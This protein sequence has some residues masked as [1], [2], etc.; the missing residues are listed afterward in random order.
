VVIQRLFR[1]MLYRCHFI[2]QVHPRIMT[3]LVFDKE[4]FL[5]SIGENLI[6]VSTK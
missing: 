4:L 2:P 3:G 5:T 6:T 1:E